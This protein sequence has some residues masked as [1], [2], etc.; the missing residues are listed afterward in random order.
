VHH[1][2]PGEIRRVVSELSRDIRA[3]CNQLHLQCWN[4]RCCA[5]ALARNI[6]PRKKVSRH[7]APFKEP[8]Q[9]PTWHGRRRPIIRPK[10]DCS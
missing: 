2:A 8:Q 5:S 7:C 1:L 4:P 6:L 9:L 10:A 3:L